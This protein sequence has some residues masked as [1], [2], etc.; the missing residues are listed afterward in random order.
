MTQLAIVS[1]NQPVRGEMRELFFMMK[2]TDFRFNGKEYKTVGLIVRKSKTKRMSNGH[3][4]WFTVTDTGRMFNVFC[5]D[6]SAYEVK[7]GT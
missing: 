4:A 7:H 2:T 5:A 1:A 6:W 3:R